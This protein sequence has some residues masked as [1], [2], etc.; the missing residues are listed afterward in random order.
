MTNPKAGEMSEEIFVTTELGGNKWKDA[1]HGFVL[2]MHE[3]VS[4]TLTSKHTTLSEIAERLSH[5][6]KTILQSHAQTCKGED[7]GI[8]GIDLG[9]IALEAYRSYKEQ[10]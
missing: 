8:C 7:C 3:P 2:P 10:G 5:A 4:Y 1:P 9:N 6:L